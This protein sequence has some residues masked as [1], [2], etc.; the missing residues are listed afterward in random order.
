MV[1]GYWLLVIE[2]GVAKTLPATI[3]KSPQTVGKPF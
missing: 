1:I 2:A 3:L